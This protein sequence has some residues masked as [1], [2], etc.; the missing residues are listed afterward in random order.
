MEMKEAQQKVRDRRFIINVKKAQ[1][2]IK[3]METEVN[4]NV[5][6]TF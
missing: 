1:K 2:P 3:A 5:K 4:S 6:L